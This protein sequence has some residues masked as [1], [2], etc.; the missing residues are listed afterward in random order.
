MHNSGLDIFTEI[1]ET[2]KEYNGTVIENHIQKLRELDAYLPPMQSYFLVTNGPKQIYEFVSK[3]FE[4]TLGLDREKMYTIG[5]PYW[6]SHFHPDEFPTWMKILE[7]LM[8]FTMTDVTKED[9]PKLCY[10]WNFR[11][12]TAKGNYLNMLT[13]QTPTYF[14]ELGK[15]VIGIAH[16]SVIG[17]G[18]EKPLIASIKILNSKNEYETIFYKNYSQKLLSA[19]LSKRE[20]DVIRLLALNKTSKYIGEQLFISSHTV[21]GHRRNILQKLH[22]KSTGEL[23][24][25]CKTNQLF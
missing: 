9:R 19:I 13:H 11:I 5:S 22:F 16:T 8:T 6:F 17:E 14:D 7:E 3:N 12:R 10:T 23:I 15:P 4:Y 2:H 25:Y 21:D 20:L 24:Q 18:I 1:F